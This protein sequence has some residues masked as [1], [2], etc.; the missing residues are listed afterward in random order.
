MWYYRSNAV[1]VELLLRYGFDQNRRTSNELEL[2]IEAYEYVS[3]F[4]TG[5]TPLYIA[6]VT[7]K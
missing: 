5:S 7:G 4:R 6:T 1:V 2:Y 3:K